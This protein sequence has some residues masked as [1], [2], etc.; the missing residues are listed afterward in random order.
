MRKEA[1]NLENKAKQSAN[2]SVKDEIDNT[3]MGDRSGSY[4]LLSPVFGSN[5]LP[6]AD[7]ESTDKENPLENP[8]ENVDVIYQL[9]PLQSEASK[10]EIDKSSKDLKNEIDKRASTPASVYSSVYEPQVSNQLRQL[11]DKQKMEYLK[12]M[13]VL[14]QKFT[15]EQ[16][17]LLTDLETSIAPITSTPLNNNSI[18]TITTDD[19]EDFT[20]FKTCLQSQSQSIEEKTIVNDYDAKV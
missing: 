14:K 2:D 6:N 4:I 1:K 9:Q 13:E 7:S 8:E 15:E 16:Q 3:G 18:I 12:A 19:D 11:I 20:D 5:I 17:Q 10:C